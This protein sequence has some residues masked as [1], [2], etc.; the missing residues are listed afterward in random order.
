MLLA[1]ILKIERDDGKPKKILI[2][3][4]HFRLSELNSININNTKASKQTRVVENELTSKLV[5]ILNNIK[6]ENINDVINART[7]YGDGVSDIIRSAVERIYRFAVDYVA[8]YTEL[9]GFITSID[10]VKIQDLSRSFVEDFWI[11]ID[12]RVFRRISVN[13]PELNVN[14]IIELITSRIATMTLNLGTVYKTR[15][16]SV[17]TES[18]NIKP[19]AGGIS[20]KML[21]FDGKNINQYLTAV[22]KNRIQYF[23]QSRI[24]FGFPIGISEPVLV[25]MTWVTAEDERVCPICLPLHGLHWEITD[26][27]M[28]IPG[29]EYDGGSTH[30]Q[31]RCRL[32]L[33]D[34]DETELALL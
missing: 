27:N 28:L 25:V 4:T 9:E 15:Q 11:S 22:K 5:G 23:N 30:L 18:I 6:K 14:S 7:I 13:Q 2:S 24:P 8:E 20:P 1:N 34:L 29:S 10:L 33:V 12:K 16:V 21:F 26:P 19:Q 17:R 32:V 31:C 3:K